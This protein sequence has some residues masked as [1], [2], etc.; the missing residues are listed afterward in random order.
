MQLFDAVIIAVM[1]LT[2]RMGWHIGLLFS[3]QSYLINTFYL[4]L[5]LHH[6]VYSSEI[7]ISPP[8]FLTLLLSRRP[9]FQLG[10][11]FLAQAK[12]KAH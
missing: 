8:L 5:I 6:L 7:K 1:T 12:E 11:L 2:L 10:L 4:E 3:E 9:S